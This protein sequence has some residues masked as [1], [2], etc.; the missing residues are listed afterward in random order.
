[1]RAIQRDPTFAREMRCA[2]QECDLRYVIAE[3]LVNMRDSMRVY[4]TTNTKI[5]DDCSF[6]AAMPHLELIITL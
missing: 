1:M 3:D 2:E 4:V 5:E 6:V